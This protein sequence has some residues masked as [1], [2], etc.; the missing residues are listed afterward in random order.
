LT[1]VE[2]LEDVYFYNTTC[3]DG[4]LSGGMWQ[5]QVGSCESHLA[6]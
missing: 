6:P 5:T 4:T 3:P 2:V 1:T